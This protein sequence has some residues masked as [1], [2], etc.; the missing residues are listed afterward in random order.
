MT[1]ADKQLK[2]LS[3]TVI[4]ALDGMGMFSENLQRQFEGKAMAYVN[5]D[6]LGL[7]GELHSITQRIILEPETK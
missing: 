7:A 2:I 1:K 5:R 4:A 3:K 6:F